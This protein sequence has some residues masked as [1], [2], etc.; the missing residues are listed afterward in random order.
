M[1]SFMERELGTMSLLV[2]SSKGE[3]LVTSDDKI[4]SSS[5]EKELGEESFLLALYSREELI[6]C[7]LVGSCMEKE[8]GS[9]RSLIGLS[10]GK[11]LIV[12]DGKFLVTSIERKRGAKSLLVAHQC[13]KNWFYLT[14][15]SCA[16]PWKAN[17]AQRAHW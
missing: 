6:N 4:F 9:E 12:S 11:N 3:E 15:C 13:E 5:M 17:L 1:V 7:K 10:I 8:V 14:A 16:H 2:G